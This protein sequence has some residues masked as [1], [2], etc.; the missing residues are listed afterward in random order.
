[1]RWRTDRTPQ[2]MRCTPRCTSQKRLACGPPP[3]IPGAAAVPSR[4]DR[5]PAAV[6]EE[7]GERDEQGGSEDEPDDREGAPTN[8][9]REDLRQPERAG[10]PHTDERADESDRDRAKQPAGTPARNRLADRPADARDDQE[11]E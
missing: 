11:D 3:P 6:G 2:H 9:D 10:H 5:P 4:S 1:M 8:V 7:A